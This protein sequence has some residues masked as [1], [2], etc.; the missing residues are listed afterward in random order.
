MQGGKL[1][2]A[3]LKRRW[4]T[5]VQQSIGQPLDLIGQRIEHLAQRAQHRSM[6]GV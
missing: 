4:L 1:G 5:A 3:A 6:A 2:P